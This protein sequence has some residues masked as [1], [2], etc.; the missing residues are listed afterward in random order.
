MSIKTIV[1]GAFQ[2]NSYLL[3]DDETRHA[4]LIDPG[5]EGDRL[6]SII[7]ASGATLD[8]IWLTHA[9]VDHVGG[10][11]AVKRALDVPVHVHPS[12]RPLYDRAVEHG[13][14]F[15][16]TVEA[17]PAP[18]HQLAGGD[19]LRV[20]SLAFD[21]M[22]TPGHAPGHVVI[23]GNGVAFVGDCLFAGSIGRTDLPFAHAPDLVRSL[24]LIAA[25]P[26]ETVVYPG[27]GPA[28]TIARE[29]QS[30]PFLNG[31]A[32]VVGGG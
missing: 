16:L 31:M 26:P 4:V 1:V 32:R 21:V 19:V 10:I 14:K 13:A 17:P 23:H 3:I 27:H 30:N 11:A 20:G 22:H 24:E 18:D 12:D 7:R 28:T 9:H 6:V 25:L 15:G 8:A 5:D 29:R 2:E